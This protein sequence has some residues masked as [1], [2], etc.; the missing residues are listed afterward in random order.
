MLH[1]LGAYGAPADLPQL[2]DLYDRHPS[3]RSVL[4]ALIELQ[5]APARD[6]LRVRIARGGDD[7]LLLP[8]EQRLRV[9]EA[10]HGTH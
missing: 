6:A 3:L 4:L 9:L 1:Y 2:L 5:G 7:A 8:L 10:C